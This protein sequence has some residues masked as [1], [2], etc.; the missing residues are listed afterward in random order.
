MVFDSGFNPVYFMY[1][2]PDLCIASN[3]STVEQALQFWNATPKPSPLHINI[4]FIPSALDEAAFIGDN[5]SKMNIS[6]LNKLIYQTMSNQGYTINDLNKISTYSIPTIYKSVYYTGTPNTLK[7]NN[8]GDSNLFYINSNNLN[9]GDEVKIVRE[10]ATVIHTRVTSIIDHQTFQVEALT[11]PLTQSASSTHQLLVDPHTNFLLHGIKLYDPLR[12]ARINH[13]A[14]YPP[15]NVNEVEIVN[16]EPEFNYNLYTMLYPD[17]RVLTKEAAFV[18]YINR[19]GNNDVRIANVKDFNAN[20]NCCQETES[21]NYATVNSLDVENVFHLNF[22]QESGRFVWNDVTMYYVTD[23][24]DRP[25]SMVSPYFQG[26][27]TEYAIKM[28]LNN[29]L[30]PDFTI[31]NLRVQ[32]N[33]VFDGHTKMNTLDVDTATI[34]NLS[35]THVE[36]SNADIAETLTVGGR[37]GIGHD[38]VPPATSIYTYEPMSSCNISANNCSINETLFVAGTTQLGSKLLCDEAT[39]GSTVTGLRFGVGYDM[40]G[41]GSGG[42]SGGNEENNS[43]VLIVSSLVATSNISSAF[44]DINTAAFNRVRVSD[45]TTSFNVYASNMDTYN[46]TSWCNISCPAGLLNAA[47][48]NIGDLTCENISTPNLTSSYITCS[49][50]KGSNI[51]A[52]DCVVR[53]QVY[54]HTL[55]CNTFTTTGMPLPYVSWRR[56]G[57]S[58][59]WSVPGSNNYIQQSPVTMQC[60][61]LE[62]NGAFFERF[63]VPFE[64]PPVLTLSV[65]SQETVISSYVTHSNGFDIV[66]ANEN[67]HPINWIAIGPTLKTALRFNCLD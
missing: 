67:A 9:V 7:F 19:Y 46:I 65:T 10:K 26:L 31:C 25:L 16:V 61:V 17:S 4:D 43:N 36:F 15:T 58:N 2:N 53:G 12:I 66:V 32:G 44:A 13:L 59:D 38:T 45:T 62:R 5:K 27:I 57:D 39:F 30:F 28:Y 3:I 47:H 48:G 23:N 52:L 1:L 56:G 14:I 40:G 49:N 33:A 6:A 54:C 55:V 18:D 50:L 35:A 24:P 11:P 21:Y 60:G 34:G 20:A 42:G 63:S 51:S 8:P 41:S 37:I 64:A 22:N 29:L